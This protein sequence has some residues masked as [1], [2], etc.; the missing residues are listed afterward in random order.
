MIFFFLSFRRSA[1]NPSLFLIKVK[2]FVLFCPYFPVN[3][4]LEDLIVIS[5]QANS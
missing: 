5:G 2:P 3:F 4:K 1:G